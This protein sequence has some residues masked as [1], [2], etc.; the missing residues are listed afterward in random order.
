MMRRSFLQIFPLLL[1]I[2][3]TAPGAVAENS[4]VQTTLNQFMHTYTDKLAAQLGQGTRVEYTLST[5]DERLNLAQCPAPLEASTKDPMQLT[6]RL[7][8]LVGCPHTWS[9]Y[10][11][12][13]MA[14]F[15]PVVTA[16]KPLA[17]GSTVGS[18]DVQLVSTDITQLPAQYLTSLRDAIGKSVIHTVA[19]GRELTAQQLAPPLLIHRGEAVVIN[20]DADAISVKMPGIA[21]ADGRL[22][23]QIRVKNANSSRVIDARV[24]APGQVQAPM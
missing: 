6:S 2:W 5:L 18:A 10:V 7:S 15:R 4:A 8:V 11:P 17:L 21:L 16:M 19:Q 14:I 12:V 24:T 13:E 23:E 1:A 22:G 3:A 9:I 20:A